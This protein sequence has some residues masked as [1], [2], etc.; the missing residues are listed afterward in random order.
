MVTSAADNAAVMAVRPDDQPKAEQVVGREA[1]QAA[2]DQLLDQVRSGFSGALVLR[3]EAGIG[4]TVLLRH[5]VR[6]AADFRVAD[7]VGIESE[8]KLGF[9]G[10]HQLVRP[11]LPLLPNLPRP[12]RQ[13][14][15]TTIGMVD[16]PPP[17]RFLVGLAVLNLLA[18]AATEKALLCVIDDA[19]WLDQVSGE[20]LAFVARR[21]EADRIGFLFAVREPAERVSALDGLPALTVDGLGR[22]DARR[23]LADLVPGA[24]DTGV[25]RR[26]AEQAAGNPLALIELTKELTAEQLAGTHWLPDPLPLAAD[27]QTRFVRRVAALPHETR[28]LLLLAAAEPSGDPDLLERAADRLGLGD[29]TTY[30]PSC[31]DMLVIEDRVRFRHPLIRSAAYRGAT[32]G[33]RRRVHAAIAG[34]LDPETD[35]DEVAWHRAAAASS[36]DEDIAAALER[37]A[38]RASSRGG[39]AS[40]AAFLRRSAE[41]SAEPAAR[42]ERL[43]AAAAAELR[44]GGMARVLTLLDRAEPDLASAAHRA[45]ALRLR[46]GIHFTRGEPHLASTTLMEAAQIDDDPA[47]ANELRLEAVAAA[48]YSGDDTRGTVLDALRRHR[49]PQPEGPGIADLLLDGFMARLTD[50]P[51]AGVQA[52]RA[53]IEQLLAP[54]VDQADELRWLGLGMWAAFELFDRTALRRMAQRWVVLCRDRGDLGT[55]PLALDFLG[56]SH[57]LAGDLDA[58]RSANIQGRDILD[59]TGSPDMLGTRAV[60]LLI[61]VWRGQESNARDVA[62]ALMSSNA[63]RSQH[64]G[65][66]FGHYAMALLELSLC[67]YPAALTHATVLLDDNGPAFGAMILPEAVE[68]AVRCGDRATAELAIGR[69]VEHHDACDNELVRGLLARCRALVA[70]DEDAEPLFDAAIERLSRCGEVSE[71]GRAHLLYGEWLRRRRRRSDAREHLRTAHQTFQRL[72][73]TGFAE[74]ARAELAASGEKARKRSPDNSGELTVREAQIADLV[75]SGAKNA[76]IAAQL[77]IS[78]STVE[79]HLRHMFQKLDVGSRTQLV[80]VLRRRGDSD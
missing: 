41:L 12:Q 2:I 20:V 53:G 21:V 61:P 74:R 64:A 15:A 42:A 8:W 79:Y 65:V 72:G 23:L 3:G 49:G 48:L 44:A 22:M 25:Q 28:T 36:P 35:P 5:A 47:R 29:P 67:N 6:R 77:F 54:G 80:V 32:S 30:G 73:A 38:D 71:L 34:A 75:G 60:E 19:Q 66:H 59:A 10:L 70:R 55:L 24:I 50:G 57:V 17:D 68:A 45:A 7:V 69:L 16:G 58:A 9:A 76:E 13:A 26:L 4:K 31:A 14:L 62:V 63:E 39:A 18:E 33:A 37:S 46:G 40:S 51:L 43:L 56:F 78:T 11:F 1:E 52:L 27:M